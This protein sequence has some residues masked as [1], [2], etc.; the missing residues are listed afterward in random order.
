MMKKLLSV[1]FVLSLCL[2][3]SVTAFA[4][5][6]PRLYDGADL[7]ADSEEKELLSRINEVS[8][9]FEVEIVIATFETIGDYSADDYTKDYYHEN[10]YGYGTGRD[11]VLLLLDMEERDY[12]IFSYGPIGEAAITESDIES[13]GEQVAS[14][15]SDGEYFTAFSTFVDE[16]AYQIDGEIN[17]FAYHLV[18]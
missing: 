7:L 12:R 5:E 16:C 13:I 10:G 14:F 3:L 2:A 11:G 1:V 17:G 18:K 4:A 9:A 6:A 8:D 15:L